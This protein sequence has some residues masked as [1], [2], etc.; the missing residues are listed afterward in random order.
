MKDPWHHLRSYTQARIAQG[1]AGCSLPTNAL[2]DFQLAH[3]AARDAVHQ[4]WDVVDFAA[5]LQRTGLETIHL[6][7]KITNRVE[8]LQRPDLGRCLHPDSAELLQTHAVKGCDVV[9]I[10]SNGL[11][12]TAVNCHGLP[13]L[14]AV[15]TALLAAG[16]SLGPVCL[17]PNARVA[18]VDEIGSI[19]GAKV[20]LILLGERPGLS[21]AD[22]LGGYLTYAPK[23]GNTDAE[24][25]CLSN[26]R[27][28]E[29]LSYQAAATKLAYLAAQ[30]L[31]RG[32]SGV[33]LKDDMPLALAEKI[34]PD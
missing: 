1:R 10:V 2:L 33:N 27:M 15:T 20:S 34:S 28:P 14:G 19:L 6:N 24:R 23:I 4:G 21:A 5:Q 13:L 29:G 9:L 26:I 11:S 7:T 3:A 30:A 22:S 16:L 32:L 8:Y 18:V 17:V 12:S 25:N 31:R